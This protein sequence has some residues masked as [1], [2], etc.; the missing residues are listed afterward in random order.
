[1]VISRWKAR[2]GREPPLPCFCREPMCKQHSAVRQKCLRRTP[3]CF[4]KLLIAKNWCPYCPS[5]VTG[6]RKR[7][8]N[9]NR[10]WRVLVVDDLEQWR[11]QLVETLQ[12]DGYY[13]GSA[14]TATE[15]LQMLDEALYHL[16]ILDI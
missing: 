6:R 1:M 15:V 2:W 5:T 14:S 9:M 4:L 7:R 12:G 13:A 8:R 10:Q 3:L 11:E 16:L